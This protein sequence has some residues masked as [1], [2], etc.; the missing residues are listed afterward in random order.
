MKIILDNFGPIQHLEIDL[1]ND[2]HLLYGQNS[3]GKSYAAYVVYLVV[4][5][6]E[7]LEKTAL[8]F[9]IVPMQEHLETILEKNA[10]KASVNL[11]DVTKDLLFKI[12]EQNLLQNLT[13]YFRNSFYSIKSLNSEYSNE[14]FCITI[15]NEKLSFKIVEH[16]N[17]LTLTDLELKEKVSAQKGKPRIGNIEVFQIQQTWLYG[18]DISD[19]YKKCIFILTDDLTY[20]HKIFFLPASRSGLYT[21]VKA[22]SPLIAELQT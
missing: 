10:D 18:V 3:V 11:T 15:E 20:I 12:I 17:T 1:N 9:D 13:N 7:Y 6:M 21:G 22:L 16:E 5:A 4:K 14:K 2:I 8:D 19:L